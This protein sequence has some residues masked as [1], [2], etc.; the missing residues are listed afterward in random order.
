M[1]AASTRTSMR[2]GLLAAEALDRPLLQ[3]AQ[4]LGLQL[5]RHVAD[6]VEIERAAVRSSSLPS[7]RSFASVNAPRSCPNISDSR[8]V[9]GIAAHETAT[10]GRPARRL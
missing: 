5:D 6:L 1:V 10:K 3:R 4:E 7:R 8:S 2:I 9:A